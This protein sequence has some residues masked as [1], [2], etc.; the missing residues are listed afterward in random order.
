MILKQVT[1]TNIIKSMMT[2]PEMWEKI[3]IDSLDK[4]SFI[5]EMGRNT[6][7]IGAFVDNVI[8][9]HVFARE[10]VGVIYHPM[11]LKKF[12]KEFGREFITKGLEWFFDNTICNN[13]F[14]DVP[15]KYKHNINLAKNFNFKE[16]EAEDTDMLYS[17][18]YQDLQRL[19]LER[20]E[21]CL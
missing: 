15:V 19:R 20:G 8:G 21:L 13:I 7:V 16:V 14:V 18:E 10:K 12:R 5:P 11:L 2:D 17:K 9:L 3:K 4:I 6:M 1:D